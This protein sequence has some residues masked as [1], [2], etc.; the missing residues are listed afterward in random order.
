MTI[1]TMVPR[2]IS[3]PPGFLSRRLHRAETLLPAPI[4]DAISSNLFRAR[5]G[6][7]AACGFCRR[8]PRSWWVGV[9]TSKTRLAEK[10]DDFKR[11]LEEASKFRV[12]DQLALA[13]RNASLRPRKATSC[14][15]TSRAKLNLP[16][17]CRER[18]WGNRFKSSLNWPRAKRTKQS[19]LRFDDLDCFAGAI[20]AV[21]LAP[22]RLARP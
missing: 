2:T 8:A 11:R 5:G 16:V 12:A 10:K 1:T 15:G 3:A 17:R 19:I 9:I 22:T 13:S 4:H 18:V 7:R 6:F 20:I 14:T 21:A